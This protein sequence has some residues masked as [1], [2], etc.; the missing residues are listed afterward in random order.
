MHS[1]RLDHRPEPVRRDR[2]MQERFHDPYRLP[3][4]L[5]DPSVCPRC[6]AVYENGRWRWGVH[7]PG[8]DSVVCQACHRVAD[9]IPAGILTLG[10]DFVRHHRDELLAHIRH[11]EAAEN[12]EHPLHR[13]IEVRSTDDGVEITTTDIHLPRRIGEALRRT[14]QGELTI[15]FDEGEYFARVRWHAE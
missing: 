8:S 7:P 2:L 6:G 13:I 10:G 14:H 1:E 5:A 3:E 11:E 12:T 15:H 9:Q 4:K